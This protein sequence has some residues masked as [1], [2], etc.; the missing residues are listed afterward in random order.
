M[1]KLTKAEHLEEARKRIEVIKE[2]RPLILACWMCYDAEQHRTNNTDLLCP[3][4][5]WVRLTG[6]ECVKEKREY[7]NDRNLKMFTCWDSEA[8]NLLRDIVIPLIKATLETHEVFRQESDA[9]NKQQPSQT[10]EKQKD[11]QNSS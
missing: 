5:L 6:R 9:S 3:Q 11:K 4:C 2:G 10:V 7:V 8:A 1:K